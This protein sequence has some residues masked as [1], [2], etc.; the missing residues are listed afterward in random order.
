MALSASIMERSVIREDPEPVDTGSLDRLGEIEQQLQIAVSGTVSDAIE[1]ASV[2]VTF[3][4]EFSDGTDQRYSNLTEPQISTGYALDSTSDA[5][6]VVQAYVQRPWAAGDDPGVIA[7]AT[8]VVCAWAPGGTDVAFTGV[9][10]VAL[11]G[12]GT[13]PNEPADPDFSAD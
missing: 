11:Q 7:G 13:L 5:P 4:V 3:D 6:V 12:W 2:D 1:A 9:V 10:H 8:I